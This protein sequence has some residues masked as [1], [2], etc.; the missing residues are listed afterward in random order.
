MVTGVPLAS[1]FKKVVRA[2]K[3]G[4][5]TEV[6]VNFR[7]N[8]VKLVVLQ[9]LNLRRGLWDA[10]QICEMTGLRYS[11]VHTHLKYW[12]DGMLNQ[13]GEPVGLLRRFPSVSGGRLAWRYCLGYPGKR[14][15]AGVNPA[16]IKDVSSKLVTRWMSGVTD[17]D[18]PGSDEPLLSLTS[19]LKPNKPLDVIVLN[20]SDKVYLKRENG[21]IICFSSSS[22]VGHD[23]GR[24]P[25]NAKWSN[26]VR[27]VFNALMDLLGESNVPLEPIFIGAGLQHWNESEIITPT[28]NEIVPEV[29]ADA[30]PVEETWEERKAQEEAYALAAR[31]RR[32]Y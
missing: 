26:D 23:V 10:R 18:I 31:L 1:V 5:M 15:L 29:K 3:R 11:T 7:F 27:E 32:K 12:T 25:E 19:L 9:A 16:L 2:R 21:N 30:A 20:P 22:W 4:N 28:N 6:K 8:L 17:Y 13:K 24:I 14:W